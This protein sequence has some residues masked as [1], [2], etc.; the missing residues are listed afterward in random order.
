MTA[1]WSQVTV[2][3]VRKAC[4]RYDTGTVVPKQ[5]AKSTFLVVSSALA[6]GQFCAVGPGEGA[7]PRQ[8]RGPGHTVWPGPRRTGRARARAVCYGGSSGSRRV[9]KATRS[10]VRPLAQRLDRRE[11]DLPR[12]PSSLHH[13][14]VADQGVRPVGRLRRCLLKGCD[15][16]YRPAHP[17][18]RYCSVACR[19]AAAHWRRVKARRRYRA[20][21]GGRD[22]W[23]EQQRRLPAAVSRPDPGRQRGGE[24]GPAPAFVRAKIFWNDCVIDL[25]VILRIS[26][27]ARLF[28]PAFL[29]CRM[30]L[31]VTARAG[32]PSALSSTAAALGSPPTTEQASHAAGHVVN[33]SLDIFSFV[34]LV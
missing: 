24:R 8:K 25:V 21:N 13:V 19:A 28:R 15:R 27:G 30:S 9:A 29:Q 33:T 3:H 34:K 12:G 1:D 5:P 6:W 7:R 32:W 23:R 17:Q 22:R 11:Q 4:E 2:D 18:S 20:S 16:C 31:G 10:Q 14:A 26:G